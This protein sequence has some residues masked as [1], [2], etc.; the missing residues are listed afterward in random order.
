[1]NRRDKVALTTAGQGILCAVQFDGSLR[2]AFDGDLRIIRAGPDRQG[3]DVLLRDRLE[4]DGLPD[5]GNRGVPHAAAV[6]F[7]LSPGMPVRQVVDGGDGQ[8]V[9]A[10]TDQVRDIRAEGEI[11]FLMRGGFRAVDADDCLPADG[12]EMEQDPVALPFPGQ[13]ETP[14]VH[15]FPAVLHLQGQSG[16]QAF[17]TERNPD[18]CLCFTMEKIPFPVQ[19][20]PLPADQLRPGINI[21]GNPA[22]GFPGGRIKLLHGNPPI[23]IA[24]KNMLPAVSA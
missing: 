24:L 7:L 16:K 2:N 9:F 20:Q 12:A 1:M 18:F 4:P 8:F 10:G 23:D 6:L 22:Q 15:H 11:A 14:G 19:A 5:T 21:P 3:T 17:R 13:D